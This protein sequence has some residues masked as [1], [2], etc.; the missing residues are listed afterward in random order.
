MDWHRVI[1]TQSQIEKEGMLNRL[2]DKFLEVFMKADDNTDM[3]LL[4]DDDYQNDRIGIYFSPASYTPCEVMIRFYNGVPCDAPAREE[5]FVLAGD[6]D[7]L[8]TLS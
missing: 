1:L 3:A 7:V 8:D 6:E 5:V 2:K 4:S